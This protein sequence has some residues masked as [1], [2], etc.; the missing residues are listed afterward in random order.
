[1]GGRLPD[2]TA[3]SDELFHVGPASVARNALC[4][5]EYGTGIGDHPA[6]HAALLR[7]RPLPEL[8]RSAYHDEIPEAPDPRVRV[9]L[10]FEA[11]GI[12]PQT[13]SEERAGPF[14]DARQYR[15]ARE[16]DDVVLL[17]HAADIL[18]T[19]KDGIDRFDYT[20]FHDVEP[21]L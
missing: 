14:G 5:E 18:S 13:A 19:G 9:D 15:G 16:E 21:L 4:A 6:G 17:F 12:T 1:M 3:R 2:V 8:V 10:S 11:V 7:C 20:R